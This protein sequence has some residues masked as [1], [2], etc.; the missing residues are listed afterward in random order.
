MSEMKTMIL[1]P[2]LD[3]NKTLRFYWKVLL[4]RYK[5]ITPYDQVQVPYKWQVT[6]GKR[7]YQVLGVLSALSTGSTILLVRVVVATRSTDELFTLFS[8]P[9]SI[10]WNYLVA[11]TT[12][13]L[14]TRTVSHFIKKTELATRPCIW[15]SK[16]KETKRPIHQT[17]S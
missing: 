2:Q 17:S 4:H 6:E 5:Y 9:G 12:A 10:K 13:Q 3:W 7:A 1:A 15:I 8:L 11:T 16:N 14:D